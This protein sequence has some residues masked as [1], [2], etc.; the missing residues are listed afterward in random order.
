MKQFR[1]ADIVPGCEATVRARR[2]ERVVTIAIGHLGSAHGLVP[3]EALGE[4]VRARVTA[5]SL[6]ASLDGGARR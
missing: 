1:C 5:T 4:R 6:V 3:D 2:V